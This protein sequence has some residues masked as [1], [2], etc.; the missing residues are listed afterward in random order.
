MSECDELAWRLIFVGEA[1]HALRNHSGS[2]SECKLS[3]TC[4]L[5]AKAISNY[6]ERKK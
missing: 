5:T 6:K 2:F 4:R 3:E 1:W